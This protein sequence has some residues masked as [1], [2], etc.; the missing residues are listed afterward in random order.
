[1]LDG[2]TLLNLAQTPSPG[3][4]WNEGEPVAAVATPRQLL[5]TPYI[6]K[7]SSCAGRRPATP[8]PPGIWLGDSRY[9]LRQSLER[10]VLLFRPAYAGVW[11]VVQGLRR[12]EE[13][14]A[15]DL[16]HLLA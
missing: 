9:L 12:G 7:T 6:G 2:N 13:R 15:V 11:I 10:V 5:S 16:D 8:R 4:D 3:E 1:D 14:P